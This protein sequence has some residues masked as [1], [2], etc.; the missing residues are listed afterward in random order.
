MSC[1]LRRAATPKPVATSPTLLQTIKVPRNLRQ[2]ADRLPRSQYEPPTLL[3]SQEAPTLRRQT[4]LDQHFSRRGMT[5]QQL[6]EHRGVL[7]QRLASQQAPRTDPVDMDEQV[8]SSLRKLREK[9]ALH[10]SQRI[11]LVKTKDTPPPQRI[12]RHGS[13]P[14][15][16]HPAV[17]EE[18]PVKPMASNAGIERSKLQQ[19]IDTLKLLRQKQLQLRAEA[20]PVKPEPLGSAR[21]QPLKLGGLKEVWSNK[22]LVDSQR[23][24]VISRILRHQQLLMKEGVTRK[25][26]PVVSLPWLVSR[27][28]PEP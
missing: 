10:P 25:A 8:R 6:S 20:S 19:Q 12:V 28:P 26:R 7:H 13:L 5:P 21:G 24:E 27:Q 2:L 15:L 9:R 4:S 22:S 23:A 17:V 18:S 1:A 11:L 3:R 14:E 16:R